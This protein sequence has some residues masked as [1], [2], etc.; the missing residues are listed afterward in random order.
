[1]YGVLL[2]FYLPGKVAEV[3]VWR[4]WL[5]SYDS[6]CIRGSSVGSRETCQ[7][8]GAQDGISRRRQSAHNYV[9][10]QHNA[11]SSDRKK[12]ARQW[13]C[14]NPFLTLSVPP[15]VQPELEDSSTAMEDSKELGDQAHSSSKSMKPTEKKEKT[16][17]KVCWTSL[18]SHQAVGDSMACIT[19]LGGCGSLGAVAVGCG[20]GL[21][22]AVE[23][24]R[25]GCGCLGAC[26]LWSAL[27]SLPFRICCDRQIVHLVVIFLLRQSS[28][29]HVLCLKVQGS[30]VGQAG[31]ISTNQAV[32]EGLTV[33]CWRSSNGSFRVVRDFIRHN[34]MLQSGMHVALM[35][36]S[37][38]N[39][40]VKLH[41]I[42][43]CWVQQFRGL[44]RRTERLPIRYHFL[45]AGRRRKQ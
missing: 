7:S 45:D 8:L 20:C 5:F 36:D 42:A 41:S 37:T 39:D 11:L 3:V 25:G 4:W 9:W 19:Q 12:V 17:K 21:L 2:C 13:H 26:T 28:P 14:H 10:P 35:A 32:E 29:G 16:M 38:T 40:P 6:V 15:E 33:K 22:E 1:M 34:I 18:A 23:E 44:F 27:H 24:V 43:G 30:E 31:R